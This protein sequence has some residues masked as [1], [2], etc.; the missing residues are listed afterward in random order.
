MGILET[1]LART[2]GFVVSDKFTLADVVVGLSVHRWFITPIER[3]DLPCVARYYDKLGRRLGFQA[4]GRNG[5]PQLAAHGVY[6]HSRVLPRLEPKRT[7]EQG[8]DSLLQA[9]FAHEDGFHVFEAHWRGCVLM[10]DSKHVPACLKTPRHP[11]LHCAQ[12]HALK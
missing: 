10:N 8:G 5:I 3:P 6:G 12:L 11:V 1:Q 9:M 4:H 7:T 2:S